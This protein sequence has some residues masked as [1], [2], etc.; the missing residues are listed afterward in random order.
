MSEFIFLTIGILI[1]ASIY[2]FYCKF[3]QK[4][5]QKKTQKNDPRK[6]IFQTTIRDTIDNS[7]FIVDYEIEEISKTKLK[8]KI[9]VI[10]YKSA[11]SKY[12]EECWKKTVI[13]FHDNSWIDSSLIDWIESDSDVS[14]VRDNKIKQI[15]S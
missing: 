15:L 9:K 4:K 3:F 2:H 7:N 6:G 13:D 1:G 12:N 8:T 14:T 5:T 10:D 11:K